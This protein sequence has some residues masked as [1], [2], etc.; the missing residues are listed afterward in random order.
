[1]STVD[2]VGI[3]FG[4]GV[5][6]TAA[7]VIVRLRRRDRTTKFASMDHPEPGKPSFSVAKADQDKGATQTDRGDFLVGGEA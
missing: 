2:I 4:L 3:L 5:L 1:M 6:V 7:V